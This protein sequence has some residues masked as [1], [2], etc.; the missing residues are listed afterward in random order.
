M[1]IVDLENRVLVRKAK[2]SSPAGT[3][4]FLKNGTWIL[5][6]FLHKPAPESDAKPA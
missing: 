6:G 4:R 1:A 5:A 2:L 3:L